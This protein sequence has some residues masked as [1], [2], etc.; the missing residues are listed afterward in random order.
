MFTLL[1]GRCVHHAETLNQL[2]LAAMTK[3]AP[4]I[5]GVVPGI[6]G[7]LAAVIDR[8]LAF[9]ARNRWADA[10]AMQ[11]ALRA[12]SPAQLAAAPMARTTLQSVGA[13][14]PPQRT[15]S[16]GSVQGV[17][18]VVPVSSD[19]PT[20]R[21]GGSSTRGLYAAFAGALAV[22]AAATTFVLLR[23]GAQALPV[24]AAATPLPS[25]NVVSTAETAAS[26]VIAPVVAPAVSAAPA[27]SVAPAAIASIPTARPVVLAPPVKSSRPV[28]IA[29]PVPVKTA[30]P[31]DPLEKF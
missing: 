27:V 5:A 22:A 26:P 20:Q 29:P 13:M 19:R 15:P 21:R 16:G 28:V 3:P 12:I 8:S 25:V 10:R 17:S 14:P 24:V 30:R 9:D 18:T 23:R 11:H 1:S 31:K 7:A 6:P 2:L 4:P